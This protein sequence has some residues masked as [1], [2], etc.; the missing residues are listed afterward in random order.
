M[1]DQETPT[2]K[3]QSSWLKKNPPAPVRPFIPKPDG[4]PLSV[5]PVEPL[6]K[7][8]VGWK[9]I[10][11]YLGVTQSVA[12]RWHKEYGMPVIRIVA[13]RVFVHR[14]ALVEWFFRLDKMQRK[15]IDETR[16]KLAPGLGVS[17]RRTWLNYVREKG[18]VRPD[19]PESAGLGGG[20]KPH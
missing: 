9:Q 12:V 18:R 19:D 14:D 5:T 11:D 4:S 1:A 20:G 16:D 13:R 2:E 15:F 8:L 3:R 10:A 7:M 6:P 17:H